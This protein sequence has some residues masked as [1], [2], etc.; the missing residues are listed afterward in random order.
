[1]SFVL[2]GAKKI[3]RIPASLLI[4]VSYGEQ[5][6]RESYRKELLSRVENYLQNRECFESI[7]IDPEE[8]TD[9]ILSFIIDKMEF[10]RQYG[11]SLGTMM[12]DQSDPSV[13]LRQ[14]S[15]LELDVFMQLKKPRP[16]NILMQKDIRIRESRQKMIL[17]EDTYQY[18]WDSTL[19]SIQDEVE[20]KICRKYKKIAKSL[21]QE[22][23]PAKK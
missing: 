15:Y 10:S 16:D 23:K 11:G 13:R 12:S 2:S 3:E 6:N 17:D 1:M 19:N 5:K 4:T 14:V 20:K 8:E 7:T 22:K 21:S 18:V 9:L